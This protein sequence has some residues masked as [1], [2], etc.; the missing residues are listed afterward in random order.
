[1]IGHPEDDTREEVPYG[2]RV[3]SDCHHLEEDPFEVE[4]LTVI[5]EGI[6]QDLPMGQIA[7]ALNRAGHRTRNGTSW[8]QVAVFEMM[9]R[10]VEFSPRLL[11]R[12]TWVERR[13]SLKLTG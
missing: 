13:Q 1:M 2:M 4:V 12:K 9:P 7:D 6:V 5:M 10:V 3:S 11:R 8:S